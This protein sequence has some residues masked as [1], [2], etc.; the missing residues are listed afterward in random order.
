M[1]LLLYI[2][3]TVTIIFFIRVVRHPVRF[4]YISTFYKFS[5][6]RATTTAVPGTQ[7]VRTLRRTLQLL[8]M[9]NTVRL[10]FSDLTVFNV[11]ESHIYTLHTNSLEFVPN[12]QVRCFH[13]DSR[14]STRSCSHCCIQ[15]TISCATRTFMGVRH[16]LVS[17]FSLL[18]PCFFGCSGLSR[19]INRK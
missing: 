14:A 18:D 3:F 6:F 13:L 12:R 11:L 10:Q 8:R 19:E 1:K 5:N 7:R 17:L 16:W 4:W 2:Y 9:P 15:A